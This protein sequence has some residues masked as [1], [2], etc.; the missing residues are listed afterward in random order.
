[1]PVFDLQVLAIDGV[2]RE[3]NLRDAFAHYNWETLRDKSVHIRGCGEITVPTWAYAMA[4]AHI[5][6]VARKISYGEEQAPIPIFE[7]AAAGTGEKE[8]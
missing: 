2:I 8:K 7:R 5:A 1:M 6:R 4:A 3:R